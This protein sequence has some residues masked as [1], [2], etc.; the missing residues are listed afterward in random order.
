MSDAVS[1]SDQTDEGAMKLKSF[2]QIGCKANRSER[3]RMEK[4]FPKKVYWIVSVVWKALE[5]RRKS[6]KCLEQW[7]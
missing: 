3:N 6:I 2:F 4:E 7:N 1:Q 5:C